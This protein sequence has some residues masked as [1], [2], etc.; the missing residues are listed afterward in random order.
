MKTFRKFR[1][2]SKYAAAVS[3]TTAL[4]PV[5]AQVL[6]DV[7]TAAQTAITAEQP[8]FVAVGTAIIGLMVVLAIIYM[9]MGMFRR[10]G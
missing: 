5:Q 2:L 7:A 8:T 9:L 10:A 3:I 6:T 4:I 1:K